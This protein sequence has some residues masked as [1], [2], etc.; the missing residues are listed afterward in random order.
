MGG[1]EESF[2]G[3]SAA[4][5]G[6][7]PVKPTGRR[8]ALVLGVVAVAIFCLTSWLAWPQI[9]FL[10]IFEPLGANAQGFPE[11]RHRQTGIVMVKLPRGKV[12]VG[13]QKTDPNGQNYDPDAGDDETVHEVTVGP[14][15]IGKYE[16]TRAQWRPFGQDVYPSGDGDDRTPAVPLNGYQIIDNPWTDTP[17]FSERTGLSL[18]SEAQWVYASR[19]GPLPFSGEPP[20][21]FAENS[22]GRLHRIGEAAPNGFGLHDMFGNV[23]EWC[24]RECKE[25][26]TCLPVR[27]G[28]AGRQLDAPP[29]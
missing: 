6:Q 3:K 19:G 9:R 25:E 23:Q 2:R 17:G 13:R 4:P 28:G 20:G 18:P 22:Q 10:W 16:V 21:W 12:W 5:E 15:L 14:F 29:S 26:R 24:I 1:V 8:V 11:Y 27:R 7:N